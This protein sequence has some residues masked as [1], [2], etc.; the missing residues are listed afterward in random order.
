M[1]AIR[2]YENGERTLLEVEKELGITPG[3]L[4]KW[5]MN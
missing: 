5:K 3:L 4:G 1:E 2:M